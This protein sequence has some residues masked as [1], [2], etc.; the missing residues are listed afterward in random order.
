MAHKKKET[1]S[2]KKLLPSISNTKNPENMKLIEVE[3]KN[4]EQEQLIEAIERSTYIFAT[5]PAGTGKSYIAMKMGIKFLLEKRV[6]KIILIRPAVTAGENLGFLPGDLDT[7]L[8]PYHIPLREILKQHVKY[9][10]ITKM[11]KEEKIETSAI[12]YMRGRTLDDAFVIVDEAQ[13]VEIKQMKMLMT[14]VGRNCTIVFDGDNDQIDVR[15]ERSGLLDAEKRFGNLDHD[16]FKVVKL[17][18]IVRNR[19]INIVLEQY[20]I[21]LDDLELPYK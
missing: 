8:D 9:A 16:E 2:I 6:N 14:R 12:A 19:L 15:E 20:Q 3:P 11:F 1:S 18:E 7:K 5:G 4:K 17:V 10:D 21:S 13:N